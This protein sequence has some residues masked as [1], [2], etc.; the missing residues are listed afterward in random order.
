MQMAVVRKNA[1]VD[2]NSYRKENANKFISSDKA[3][4]SLETEKQKFGDISYDAM[5]AIE[6]NTLDSYLPKN[7]KEKEVIYNYRLATAGEVKKD[8]GTSLGFITQEGLKAI[9]ENNT[10]KYKPI[11]EDEGKAIKAYVEY[12]TQKR[13]QILD[14][15]KKTAEEQVV[16]IEEE[17]SKVTKDILQL[18]RERAAAARSTGFNSEEQKE[19]WRTTDNRSATEKRE[20]L[21]NPKSAGQQELEGLENKKK[22]LNEK[23]DDLV[24]TI[25]NIEK[26]ATIVYNDK[27]WIDQARANYAKGRLSQDTSQAYNDYTVSQTE[28]SRMLADALSALS[29]QFE[30]NNKNALTTDDEDTN[31]VQETV[32]DWVSVSFANYLP[33]LFDQTKASVKGAT[34]GAIAGA[35]IAGTATGG[36]GVGAGAIWGA[37]AGWVAGASKQMYETT[38]GMVFKTLIDAGYDEE[39]AL[40]AANDEAFVSSIIEGAGEIVSMA[41]LGTGKLFSKI[42]PNAVKKV[43]GNVVTKGIK[44]FAQ[45]TGKKISENIFLNTTV[46]VAGVAVNALGEY[47]EEYSQEAVSIANE[48]RLQNPNARGKFNLAS[49]TLSVLK[50]QDEET[51]NRLHSA[52]TEGFRIGLMMGG[53]TVGGNALGSTALGHISDART[54]MKIKK[55]DANE[56]GFVQS[57]IDIGLNQDQNSKAY[58][59]AT[60]LNES[61][62]VSSPKLGK[63]AKSNKGETVNVGETYY[64]TK[65]KGFINIVSRDDKTTTVTMVDSDGVGF[66]KEFSNE[67]VDNLTKNNRY[68]MI[69]NNAQTEVEQATTEE[70]SAVENTTVENTTVEN[71]PTE[72]T[73][74]TNI[75]NILSGEKLT[76]KQVDNIINDQASR[77]AFIQFTGTNLEGTKAEQRAIIRN[78]FNN[79]KTNSVDNTNV[80]T[81]EAPVETT[82]TTNP[83]TELE[84]FENMLVAKGIDND[85]RQK[86]MSVARNIQPLLSQRGKT[87][88][89][90][91]DGVSFF[92]T[93]SLG[94]TETSTNEKRRKA[95]W[96]AVAKAFETPSNTNIDEH[97]DTFV[98]KA[99]GKTSIVVEAIEGTLKPDAKETI[100]RAMEKQGFKGDLVEF[101]KK[102]KAEFEKNGSL[103]KMA[104]YFTDN[105]Q[106]VIYAIERTMDTSDVKETKKVTKTKTQNKP[107]ESTKKKPVE[108]K[109]IDNTS[110]ESTDETTTTTDDTTEVTS[111]TEETTPFSFDNE[112]DDV[113]K[114]RSNFSGAKQRILEFYKNNP[115]K[116]EAIEYLKKE[117]GI[118]GNSYTFSN[119]AKGMVNYDGKGIELSV[120]DGDR[121]R[122]SWSEVDKRIRKLIENGEYAVKQ[123]NSST[124]EEVD[125]AK[126]ATTE[127]ELDGIEVEGDNQIKWDSLNARQKQAIAFIKGLAQKTGMRLVLVAHNK[128][129]DGAFSIKNNTIYI[130]VFAGVNPITKANN[131]II[132]T[133]SHEITHWMEHKSPE[134]WK[135]VNDLV[136]STLQEADGISESARIKA[137]QKR[138][139]G[140]HGKNVSENV[141]RSEIIARAC[142]DMLSM[143]EQGK[144]I[145]NSLSEAEQQTFVAK[146]KEII[147]NLLEWVDDFLSS[148][149]SDKPEAKLMRQYKDKLNE[150]SKLWDEMLVD[151]IKTNQTLEKN[152]VFEHNAEVGEAVYDSVDI[153]YNEKFVKE[154]IEEL[155]ANHNA[156]EST[157]SVSEILTRYKKITDIWKKLG[158]ELKSD[159]LDEWNNK[160][161][162]DQAFTVFKA[163]SGYKYNI[164]LSSMCKKGIPLF[165]AIDRIVRKEVMQELKNKKLGKAEKEILYDLLKTNGF[166]IPCAICYVEQA[167]QREGDIISAFLN[168]KIDKTKTGKVTTYKLGWN[169]T[170]G[171]IQDEMKKA[172]VDYT[173]PTL[174]RSV[175]TDK[176][177]PADIG[178]DESTQEAY[179][180]ALK[181]IANAEIRRYNKANNKNIKLITKTD[182]KSL[183]DTFKGNLPLNLRMFKT[184]F[185]EPSSRF[186]IGED[187]LYSSMTTLNL[188]SYHNGLYSVF[189]S[190]GGTG[191]Y[192]TKQGTVVYWGDIL[193]KK[194]LP[195]DLRKEGGVRNQSNSDF[196]MYTLLDH[197]QMYLDFTAKGYYLQA[198]TKVLAELKL[199]GLSNGKHN[200]S[201]IPRV[202]VY[203]NED[204]SIDVEKTMLYA[205]LD[206]DGNPIYDDIEG[207]PHEEAFMLLEDEEYS[208]SVGGVCIGYSDNHILKLL[209]DNRIQLII[210]FH[211]KTDDTSKRYKGAK[212]SKNYNG[213]NEATSK[214]SGETK[215]IGFNQFIQKAENKFKGKESVTYKDK[216][217]TWN[218][219]PK[220]AV[221]LYLEHC[222]KKGLYPAYSQEEGRKGTD[223]SKHPNYYKLLADFSLYDSKGNYAPHQKVEYNMP[224]QVPYLDENGKK[225]YMPTE[226]YIKQELQKEIA[227]RD[228]ISEK[229]A[230]DSED[231]IIQQFIQRVN[232]LYENGGVD[233]V[234]ADKNSKDSVNKTITIDMDEDERYEILKNKKITL[235]KV[236]TDLYKKYIKEMPELLDKKLRTQDAKKLLKRL[237]DEFGVYKEYESKD[238]DIKFEFGVNNLNKSVNT[239]R[240]N[241]DK[242]AQMLSCFPDVISN[243]V[244][245]EVHNRNEEGYKTDDTLK[246][247]YVLFSAFENDT[248]IVPVK[249]SV[250]EFVDKSNRLYLAISLESIKKDRVNSMGVQDNLTHIRT[251]SVTVSIAELFKNVNIIDADFL[252]YLPNRFLN[253]EQIEAKSVAIE[254]DKNKYKGSNAGYHAGDL[255]KAESLGTQSGGR[256]TGHFGTGT[257]FV[258]N[259]EIVKDYNKRDGASAPQ[260]AVDFS[261]YNLFKPKNYSD[262]VKVHNFLGTIN[263]F[264]RNNGI[265]DR[266]KSI[267][268]VKN[269][270]KRADEIFDE[271]MET[272]SNGKSNKELK[273][274]VDIY[275]KAFGKRYVSQQISRQIASVNNGRIDVD[276]NPDYVGN[277]KAIELLGDWAYK[278]LNDMYY[279]LVEEYYPEDIINLYDSIDDIS[280]ILGVDS[281]ELNNAIEDSIK[282]VQDL[283]LKNEYKDSN[284]NLIDSISTRVMKKLGFDGVDVRGIE[285]LD[286]TTYGSVIYD[287]QDADILYAEK[288]GR[289]TTDRVVPNNEQPK[290]NNVK[291]K[292]IDIANKSVDA[293]KEK[294][295]DIANKAIDVANKIPGV[296]IDHIEDGKANISDIVQMIKD[297]FDVP[298]STGKVTVPN[299]RGI[300]KVLPEAIR[301]KIA[302]NLPTISHELGHHIDKIYDFALSKL[303]SVKQLRNAVSQDFLNQYPESQRNAEAVAEF[304]RTYLRNTNEAKDLC[305]D[306]YND[307]VKTLSKED[308][309]MVD[310]IAN[311]SNEYLSSGFSERVQA[312][313]VSGNQKQKTTLSEKAKKMHADWIDGYAPIKDVTDYVEET[314]GMSLSGTRN[315]YTLATNSRNARAIA[316]F[317]AVHGFRN[318]NGNIVRGANSFLECIAEVDKKNLETLDEYL[319]LKHSL[320]WINPQVEGVTKKRVFGDDTLEDVE[321]IT[322]RIAEI[323]KA[324]PEM[325]GAAQ[326]LYEYQRNILLHFV[327]PAGGMTMATFKSLYEKYPCYV[328]FYRAV[329]E[330]GKKNKTKG[331]FANQKSPLKRAKGSGE[332]IISPLESII[333]NTDKM[334]KF[335]LRNQTMQ[336][337]ANYAN[338]VEGFGKFIEKVPP[339]MLPHITNIA[340]LK[341][342]FEDALQQVVSTSN[343][344]FA[345]SNLFDEIFGESVTD[346]SPIANAN[347][348]IVTVLKNGKFEYYQ[349]HDDALYEAIAE[350]TPK[351]LEGFLAVSHKIMQPMKLLI[352]QYNF[353]FGSTN[354]LRDIGTAYKNSPINNPL[355]FAKRYVVALKEVVTRGENYK[356]WQSMGGGHNSELS[357]NIDNIKSALRLTAEKDMGKARRLLYSVVHHP[358]QTIASLNDYIESTP[359]LMEFMRTLNEGGDL[360]EAIFNADDITTNFKKSGKGAG[361]KFANSTVMF[362]N[363]ALQGLNKTYR[364]LTNKNKTERYKT[365]IKWATVALFM[366]AIQAVFNKDDEEEYNNLS[367]YKKNN[368]YNFS[369]GDGKFISIPKARENA[370]LDSFTERVVEY[371][372]GNDEAFYDFFGGYLVDQLL[373]PMLPNTLNPIEAVHDIG[374]STVFGGLLDVGYNKNF[375]DVPIESAYDKYLPSNERYNEKTSKIAYDLGQSKLARKMDLSPKKIDHLLS[376]YTGIIGQGFKALGPKNESNRDWS[377]GLR[378]K[379]VSDSNY[380][381]DV[382]NKLYDNKDK[383]LLEWQ[384]EDNISN[385]IEYEQNAIITSY[386]SGMNKAIKGLPEDEQREGR[387]YLLKALNNWNYETTTQQNN[388]LSRL[389]GESI[390]DEYIFD[391][392]PSSELSWTVN[393]QK[394]TYQMTPQEYNEYVTVYLKAIE[395]ARKQFGGNSLESYAK[396]KEAAR[397]YMSKYKKGLT[398][399][400]QKKATKK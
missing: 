150:L 89:D 211:D 338:T 19:K 21:S 159:F 139:K 32:R 241:Y 23:A 378:N 91:Y 154:H 231:G 46:K 370:L 160:V 97:I 193:Q 263:N 104:D 40:A 57:V 100:F 18:Q 268:E 198:Y 22:V 219:V 399:K 286:N 87:L 218:D 313:I 272:L 145:F 306:F 94:A 335:A 105:G 191:G 133:M 166:E 101:A 333:N 262:G 301:I 111:T 223:F 147:K 382:L 157:L 192:K 375:M 323:E 47:A 64:D 1:N 275:E 83:S 99:D 302:N 130:D 388:M 199:F 73:N 58:K 180:N 202:V 237:G 395:N 221:D 226:A 95:Y 60:K 255:G 138:L 69:E 297:Y 253:E 175:A 72:D 309:K 123:N 33:Q 128:K 12:A 179:Y 311:V 348:K 258:G 248:E 209:D 334:V 183:Q 274:L 110:E 292:V 41:T 114:M 374:G 25:N 137:E 16:G 290:A 249:L 244:G 103:G 210:G 171:K 233:T 131:I 327:I 43:S 189:N 122:Y 74:I 256:G 176:Y 109:T 252:K 273:E 59:L 5:N 291:E 92:V 296:D 90:F 3:R 165:E 246:N 283:N 269:A 243:A 161:G 78:W 278:P 118:S 321:A 26:Y 126:S 254:K 377:I 266:Y 239:Q 174:D 316:N 376:S 379:F 124:T 332:S 35:V 225:A 132:P 149:E 136:F 120:W 392:L 363:A 325:K 173:F 337:L 271:A 164:E 300:Y 208:K 397:D 11:N 108:S 282:E 140:V 143:S 259:K 366:T 6:N 86:I 315:A 318:M 289:W 215:H 158:G 188:A 245:V 369:I 312:S 15:Y 190:Q 345:V 372:F 326:N 324:H 285:G 113:L 362:N 70:I 280:N 75:R 214:K 117:Y 54:G 257:Y 207:I 196:L 328:P 228:S 106:E 135:K 178:M 299:A 267:E 200:A 13:Q 396:A 213:L 186:I 134:L 342:K 314:L 125:V 148:Y 27:G 71:G 194:W 250:K 322:K 310:I 63:L 153:L 360:Q 320:E 294:A 341:G 168:G 329:E 2:I 127:N 129:F 344:Y 305:Y 98:S 37:R 288:D 355:E 55:A 30:Y 358:I 354:F 303:G 264:W 260:H 394:Y 10:D 265:T 181:K 51:A 308:L 387:K 270:T 44:G 14:N 107:K 295:T 8:D 172:G 112:I 201:L 232:A 242:F 352:T 385:A 393:K 317:N 50:Y 38:R 115:S 42:A 247:V 34:E 93:D 336:V 230:D 204:G 39:T 384:Y 20:G 48:R 187:L 184:L 304:V 66:A 163:Q 17:K 85:S 367:S 351:Q 222:D 96:S 279:D 365:L 212:Y 319:V 386:V 389:E 36:T 216:T 293:V 261:N 146:V 121:K 155:K 144:K 235:A 364:T 330:T 361:A 151:S 88:N 281:Q 373:P 368:F 4:F 347:K 45:K 227:V 277:L 339:D 340:Q 353:T 390:S 240:G 62:K 177:T 238:F 31:K 169:E 298:I 343:D 229:L 7:D 24:D 349:V 380:S 356:Q 77:E 142:E 170:L 182:I 81:T 287:I 400:Y 398:N 217:Y 197:A 383:A 9:S 359:R 195:E 28:E 61:E 65:S 119:G 67:A 251:S 84:D 79:S 224:D 185:F 162:K 205:G 102:L 29:E 156:D 80:T 203:Q 234:L 381:T 68:V 152:G 371:A 220:L 284:G 53:S 82:T 391:D 141:A 52:G 76:N 167:R 49:E 307:F 116:A 206:E 350:F 236:D 346:Y 276:E 56:S 357:A 331:T